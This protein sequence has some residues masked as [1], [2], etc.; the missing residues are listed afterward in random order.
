[1]TERLLIV[2][3]TSA[4]A[5]SCAHLW[6]QKYAI[7]RLVLVARNEQ[8]LCSIQTDLAVRYPAIPIE[9]YPLDDF[10]DVTKIDK[11]IKNIHCPIDT[12]LIAHGMLGEQTSSQDD[13]LL[14]RHLIDVNATSVMLFAEA[15]LK[16]MTEVGKGRLG[17]I[18]SVA[19][20]RARK[21]NY[22]YGASKAM[23]AFFC[24]G[25]QHRFADSDISISLIKPGPTNTPMTRSLELPNMA[26]TDTIAAD[27]IQG[28]AHKKR[29]IYSP[30]KW[31]WM[32][33]VLRKLPWFIFK[34][35]DI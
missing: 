4:I 13:L 28:M 19:G 29:I 2:G 3:A 8:K 30:G 32:M 9:I 11:L 23:I 22:H 7:K 33:L 5:Q 35:L 18:G 24:Q 21:K 15:I 20:D 25:L 31:R 6:C 12:A 14:L 34:R 1:M 27:I 16:K 17:I 26:S 10:D